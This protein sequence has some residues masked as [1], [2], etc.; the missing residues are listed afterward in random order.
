MVVETT[1]MARKSMDETAGIGVAPVAQTTAT[2]AA[3]IE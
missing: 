1:V 2:V 3:D